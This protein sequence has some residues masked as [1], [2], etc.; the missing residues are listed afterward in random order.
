MQSRWSF[1]FSNTLAYSHL[2]LATRQVNHVILFAAQ[3][4]LGASHIA[5]FC[6]WLSF[7]ATISVDLGVRWSKKPVPPLI[8]LLAWKNRTSSCPSIWPQSCLLLF[9]EGNSAPPPKGNFP[10][11]PRSLGFKAFS[12]NPHLSIFTSTRW[13]MNGLLKSSRPAVPETPC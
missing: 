3:K 6:H 2:H 5:S 1:L 11:L 4:S 7:H 12:W 9:R 13:P 10:G 8:A